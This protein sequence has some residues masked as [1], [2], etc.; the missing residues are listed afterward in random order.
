MVIRRFL[1]DLIIIAIFVLLGRELLNQKSA[2]SIEERIDRFNE[3]VEQGQIIENVSNIHLN[4][5]DENIAG[6]L[7]EL[8]SGWI[9]DGVSYTMEMI[10]LFFDEN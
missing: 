2:L 8:L 9:T 5:T 6:K 4:Q 3:Q 10:A 7:G 1:I